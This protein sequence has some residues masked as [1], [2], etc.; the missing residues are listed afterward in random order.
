MPISQKMRHT[1][2]VFIIGGLFVFGAMVLIASF[3]DVGQGGASYTWL[4]TTWATGV[5]ANNADH[6]NNR[7]GWDEYTSESSEVT[8]S[9]DL[10]I[11]LTAASTTETNDTSFD[12]GTD[13]S[14]EVSGSGDS[15]KVQ[16]EGSAGGSS[17]T[18]ETNDTSF[19][20]GTDS[21]T[22]VSGSGDSAKVQLAAISAA[23]TDLGNYMTALDGADEGMWH[24]SYSEYDEGFST[25]TD[26][27]AIQDDHTY[28]LWFKPPSSGA[29]LIYNTG[30]CSSSGSTWDFFGYNADGSLTVYDDAGGSLDTTAGTPL[31]D[32]SKWYYLSLQ[33][34]YNSGTSRYKLYVDTIAQ[35]FRTGG[36][37]SAGH[38]N[39]NDGQH[40]CIGIDNGGD[41]ADLQLWEGLRSV[42]EQIIDAEAYG[43]GDSFATH[44]ATASGSQALIYWADYESDPD[45]GYNT[46][47]YR[48]VKSGASWKIADFNNST[49]NTG[50][51]SGTLGYP[52]TGTFTSQIIDTTGN[53]TF[54]NVSWNSTDVAGSTISVRVRSDSAANMSGA[55]A[56]A[57]CTDIISGED[58]TSNAC[59][60]DTDQYVQ[61]EVRLG[62]AWNVGSAAYDGVTSPDVSA[63]EDFVTGVFFKPDGTKMY[64]VGR[65]GDD[66]HQYSLSAAWDV[67]TASYDS[68]SKNVNSEEAS[69]L[70]LS[71]KPDGTTM[72]VVGYSD[73][74]VEQYTLSTP[75][76]V[77]TASYD[78]KNFSVTD[79]EGSPF[80]LFFK[81]DGTK[82][83]ITGSWTN[84]VFQYTLS[85]AWDVSTASYDSKSFDASSEEGSVNGLS[86]KP[87]GT[88]MYVVGVNTDDVEQYTLSTAWDVSTA[89]YD[90]LFFDVNSEEA[91]PS[92]LFFKPDGTKFY[93]IGVGDLVY[94]YSLATNANKVSSTSLDD[95]IINYSSATTYSTTGIF[96]SQILD[97]TVNSVYGIASWNT[98]DASTTTVSVKVRTDSAAN[99]SGATAFTDTSC[100]DITSGEDISGNG[101]VTDT[102]R[103]VQYQVSL[104]SNWYV[105]TGVY[106]SKASPSLNSQDTTPGALSF[107]LDGSKLYVLG[108]NSDTVYQYTVSTPWDAST[109]SYASK[110]F[111][112][113]TQETTPEGLFFSLDGT[114]MYIAGTSSDAV[115]QYALSSAWDVSTASYAS[116]SLDVSGQGGSPSALF[117]KPDGTK[118]YRLDNGSLRIK[119]YSLSTAWDISTGSYDSKDFAASSQEGLPRDFEFKQDGTKLYIVGSNEDTVYQYTLSTPWDVSTASYDTISFAVSEESTL[120][121][122]FIK[123][124]GT[125]FYAV[126]QGNDTVYQ[127]SFA[128]NANNAGTSTLDDITINYSGY[129]TSEQNLISSAFDT[130]SSG[131]LL[132]QMAW[133]ETLPS[134]A[135][136]KFQLRTAPDST[137]SP[138]TWTDWLGPTST[139][140]YYTDSAGGETINSTHTDSTDDQWY[141]YK[142]FLNSDGTVTPTLSD[143]TI[144]YVV[145][146]APVVSNV[147]ASQ[148]SAGVVTV[149]YDFADS[150]EAT[151]TISV[152]YQ[153]AGVTLNET[154]TDSD[155]G[156]VTL[157]TATNFPASGKILIDSEIIDYSGNDG[158]D[159]T[160]VERG[161][162]TSNAAAHSSGAAVYMLAVTV[163]GDAGA[164]ITTGTS[165]SA[166]WTAKTDKDGFYGTAVMRIL[167]DDENVALQYGAANASSFNLDTKDPTGVSVKVDAGQSTANRATLTIAASD[168]NTVT[169]NVTND[170][171]YADD[172]VNTNAGTYVTYATSKTDWILESTEDTVY[173]QVKDTKGNTATASGLTP[174]KPTSPAIAEVSNTTLD[175][176][177]YGM[178]LTWNVMPEPTGSPTFTN[179]N[180]YRKAGAGS[181]S[182]IT[183]VGARATNNYSDT[184][185][186]ASTTYTYYVVMTDSDTNISQRSSEIVGITN[187][188][189]DTGEGP[190]SNDTTAP[191]I[192]GTAPTATVSGNSVTITYTA[193]ASGA[194]GDSTASVGYVDYR[195]T[196]AS[197]GAAGT[198][199]AS[200]NTSVSDGSTITVVIS[201]LANNT[202][203]YYRIG[204]EDASGNKGTDDN[205]AAGYTFTSESGPIASSGNTAG[206]SQS[207]AIDPTIIAFAVTAVTSTTATTNMQINEVSTMRVLYGLEPSVL[208]KEIIKQEL[209]NTHKLT[210]TEL[211]PNT[212]YYV[213]GYAKDFAGNES[214]SSIEQFKTSDP[215]IL[216]EVPIAGEG[217]EADK[218][219]EGNIT[220]TII[221]PEV[222]TE[223]FIV[224]L[225]FETG[226]RIDADRSV[227][228]SAMERL[229]TDFQ[230]V[231]QHVA[232]GTLS[233]NPTSLAQF[234]QVAS[235]ELPPPTIVDGLPITEA[236]ATSAA[237]SWQTD[238]LA[239][240]LVAIVPDNLYNPNA[241]DPY[242]IELGN[243]SEFVK[244]HFVSITDLRP[245]TR[246]HYQIR[247]QGSLGPTAKSR[248]YEFQTLSEQLSIIVAEVL[249]IEATRA[250]IFWRTS[251]DADSQVEYIPLNENG[252]PLLDQIGTQGRTDKSTDHTVELKGLESGTGYLLRVISR[253]GTGQEIDQF[254][255]QIQTTRDGDSPILSQINALSTLYPGEKPKV[256]T[257]ITWRTDEKANSQVEYWKGLREP[258]DEENR[259]VTPVGAEYTRN[260]VIVLTGL[261]PGDV[262]QYKVKS[263]DETGN[264]SDSEAFTLLAPSSTESVVEVIADNFSDIFGWLQVGN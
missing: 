111:L 9:T 147:T 152:Y 250:T 27:D 258:K 7:T 36:A 216:I 101:C 47:G 24:T 21:N 158:T 102:D 99:M 232:L 256:Q 38:S 141:Q 240:S 72:Y 202:L 5:T 242:L 153:L 221:A 148:N 155:T 30:T 168:D 137:G 187:G 185:L 96:T 238:T 166:T 97:T 80:G 71:F 89:S 105:S 183:T 173:I 76:D 98:T 8:E 51:A 209:A 246:Y 75:W 189:L 84:T 254:L 206:G 164:S 39:L 95:I 219:T 13:S 237:F 1:I 249:E 31:S 159:L 161:Y 156:A 149:G 180:I 92:G 223:P 68:K 241:E 200:N 136:V 119:Q 255:P 63:E 144:T 214:Q 46:T 170:S 226:I 175:T 4:Q 198:L 260:H 193:V 122:I 182:S 25:S 116:K 143:L 207:D 87:D 204:A 127:Y 86:F 244:E 213:R 121:S 56:F 73:D 61:Y 201:G 251:V 22:E 261:V 234:V 18:T 118:M 184:G 205:S 178:Y 228:E 210:I 162:D 74:E 34:D 17:S 104:G 236:T 229:K 28:E 129:S 66:V 145:N 10:T 126:G 29:S 82:M 131:V 26:G 59:V 70:T 11:T 53:S 139:G 110:S 23:S 257:L 108:Q 197:F 112:P 211:E 57:S 120:Y 165:K 248:D 253:D 19:D 224:E 179:Y 259:V 106:D 151:G 40:T 64:L 157:S 218:I 93:T 263:V 169:M 231:M 12:A 154:L 107:S 3:W 43:N 130:E 109:A 67:S 262:Y 91:T 220:E 222:E 191:T 100:T 134:G 181:Y 194:T 217:E 88:K 215:Q 54:D 230:E 48:G 235:S 113:T 94:Q 188:T 252:E 132:T 65:D 208:D 33:Y 14:T 186:A 103:Y 49:H 20:A 192:S 212:L 243:S 174:A 117:F 123:P 55:T 190:G 90:S 16:L 79:E 233:Q 44:E 50:G 135:D 52:Q 133:T 60:T 6:T 172:L 177:T 264:V 41:Y 78:S 142:V 146:V 140:D 115:Y 15:A 227:R 62:G 42:S 128:S 163:G 77:S 37:T 167:A 85:T 35:T 245:A 45:G 81:P 124:D 150:D 69:P 160:I 32:T 125:K 2:S 58:V 199:K 247:S 225:S 83:Y 239:N 176:P 114:K 138:G 203:Y 195:T 171:G 196:D